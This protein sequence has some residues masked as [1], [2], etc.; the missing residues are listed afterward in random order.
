MWE[1]RFEKI[2]RGHLP[3]LDAS[4]ELSADLELRD[5]GLDSLAMVDVLAELET[6]YGVRFRDDALNVETFRTPS[7]LWS[8]LSDLIKL[9]A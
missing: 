8:A 2:L 4:E 7:T 9:S 1:Q 6:D 3:Y 5:V